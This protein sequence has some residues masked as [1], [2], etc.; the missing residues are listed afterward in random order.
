MKGRTQR[1]EIIALKSDFKET[2]KKMAARV[3]CTYLKRR[4]RYDFPVG[5][6]CSSRLERID[7][8]LSSDS[9]VNYGNMACFARIRKKVNTYRILARKLEG[10]KVLGRH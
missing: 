4:S 8:L 2:A 3:G 7:Q 1:M 5:Y 9:G 6:L 10:K